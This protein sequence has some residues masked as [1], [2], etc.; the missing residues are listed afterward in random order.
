MY[1]KKC[2]SAYYIQ[3]KVAES[4]G[5]DHIIS[6]LGSD[7][8]ISKAAIILLYEL[9]QDRSGWN[10]SLCRKLSHHQNAISFLVSLRNVPVKESAEFSEKILMQLFDVDEGN[11]S[12]AAK[13]GW[14]KPLVNRMVQGKKT[15][16]FLVLL[17]M[18]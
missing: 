4:Q 1:S 14:Y 18:L 5:W 3:E 10:V 16:C 11:I 9:L 17:S 8:N 13:F 12:S 6:C 15:N 2:G 7:S